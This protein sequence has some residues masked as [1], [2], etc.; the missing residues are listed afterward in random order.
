MSKAVRKPR[1]S[2][3]RWYWANV[4]NCYACKN[5]NNCNQCKRLKEENA[6]QKEKLK[7]KEKGKYDE[8]K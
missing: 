2:I 6:N 5:R 3:P 7:R 1:L 8:W 4:D